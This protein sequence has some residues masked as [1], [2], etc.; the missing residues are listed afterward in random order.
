MPFLQKEGI[1]G[2]PYVDGGPL[3]TQR[4]DAIRRL[5]AKLGWPLALLRDQRA[6]N[7]FR[8]AS[9][10]LIVLAMAVLGPWV[11]WQITVRVIN[12]TS[13][14][15]ADYVGSRLG[16]TLQFLDRESSIPPERIEALNQMGLATAFGKTFVALK[17]RG[18]DGRILY[19][20]SAPSMVGLAFP[21]DPKLQRAWKG[22]I[23]AGI[24]PLEDPENAG[25]RH[26][27][28]Q[29][30]EIY[31]PIYST[32]GDHI[33]TVAEFFVRMDDL[34]GE[35]RKAR[36]FTWL[37]FGA[38]VL[39]IYLVFDWQFR[40]ADET[41]RAQAEELQAKVA[42][43]ADAMALNNELDAR[44]R[45]AAAAMTTLHEQILKRLGAE[46][47][48]GPA[49]DQS[50]VLMRFDTIEARAERCVSVHSEGKL[51]L[52][53]VTTLRNTMEKSM[54]DLR[55]ISS[56][57]GLARLREL[58]MPATLKRAVRAHEQRTGTT[59]ELDLAELPFEMPLA[60][61][62]TIYRVVQEALNNAFRH[63]GG[64]GQKVRA[65]RLNNDMVVEII[66]KGPGFDP[67]AVSDLVPEPGTQIGLLGMR[68]RIESLG[69]EFSIDSKPGKGT[70]V[71]ARIPVDAG[72]ASDV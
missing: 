52:E 32:G 47:H 23:A 10:V 38:S 1:Q 65:W 11:E 69:G 17:I 16:P 12:Q 64:A 40:R 67:W 8:L 54:R 30:L 43:L 71:T 53:E 56:G 49:Q 70:T 61:K 15:L 9:V 39:L 27:G 31:A 36:L 26:L 45:A 68:E 72:K 58:P 24:T 29:L 19:S 48:D 5:G 20:S 62:I 41:I 4:L 14:T 66:D 50:F 51:C 46:I 60:A 22:E 34:Q 33:V 35:I 6:Y 21:D 42:S 28:S 55:A 3:K 18:R 7:R 2:S 63:A 37:I 25:E 57:L 59:V 44:I 13:R